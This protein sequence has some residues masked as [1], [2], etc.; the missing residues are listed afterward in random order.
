MP[1]SWADL[2]ERAETHDVDLETL[3]ATVDER[4]GQHGETDD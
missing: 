4:D 3:R 2:F 1:S